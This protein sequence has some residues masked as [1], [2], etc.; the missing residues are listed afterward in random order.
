MPLFFLNLPSFR[1]FFEGQKT[2]PKPSQSDLRMPPFDGW[3]CILWV[4]RGKLV[5]LTGDV[6]WRKWFGS[7]WNFPHKVNGSTVR[8]TAFYR[9]SSRLMAKSLGKAW[10]QWFLKLLPEQKCNCALTCTYQFG[11]RIAFR[12]NMWFFGHVLEVWGATTFAAPNPGSRCWEQTS[13]KEAR[14]NQ[15]IIVSSL[16]FLWCCLVHCCHKMCVWKFLSPKSK[17]LA[18]SALVFG[19]W[20]VS[21]ITRHPRDA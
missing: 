6:P 2:N 11:S 21:L 18:V 19:T 9:G 15:T 12:K 17:K 7:P 14:I 13:P 3:C 16:W 8:M 4:L 10:C 1:R 20:L 5:W